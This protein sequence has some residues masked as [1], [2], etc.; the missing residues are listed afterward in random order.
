MRLYFV[1]GSGMTGSVWD[2]LRQL[3]PESV[4]LDLPGHSGGE[5]LAGIEEYARWLKSRLQDDAE[6]LVSNNAESQ[7]PKNGGSSSGAVIIGHSL[8]AGVALQLALDSPESIR[9]LVLIG[10]GARLRVMP[11][12]LES[13]QT[14]TEAGDETISD[15]VLSMTRL[16]EASHRDKINQSMQRNGASVLLSDLRA[17]DQFDVL[18]RIHEIKLPVLLICGEQ[19]IMTPPKY[20]EFLEQQLPD[21]RFERVKNASHMVFA[22]KADETARLIRSFLSELSE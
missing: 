5:C 2:P 20:S 9:A 17:C 18:D 15:G 16:I 13:L 3:F 14:Q 6:E 10:S 1:H 22:E 11:A 12:L 21:A 8:G 7:E 4:A 19:D